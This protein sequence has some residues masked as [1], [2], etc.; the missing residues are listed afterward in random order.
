MRSIFGRAKN[1]KQIGTTACGARILDLGRMFAYLDWEQVSRPTHCQELCAWLTS[2]GNQGC[3]WDLVGLGY[4]SQLKMFLY[5]YPQYSFL[6]EDI[7]IFF[8]E[9]KKRNTR[10]SWFW[11][12][13]LRQIRCQ[14]YKQGCLNISCI[15]SQCS[16]YEQKS[17][18]TRK[19]GKGSALA[20]WVFEHLLVPS[21]D[22]S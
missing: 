8:I 22:F 13:T 7:F 6:F 3:L 4:F 18:R 17:L 9:K 1:R 10:M 2:R 16:Q 19:E 11:K 20:L 21:L 14:E 15:N 12:G 5:G